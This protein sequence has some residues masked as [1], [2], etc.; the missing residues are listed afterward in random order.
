MSRPIC[1]ARVARALVA[2]ALLAATGGCVRDERAD[3]VA[4]PCPVWAADP[5]DLHSNEVATGLGCANLANFGSM[6][7]RPQDL[8]AGRP[9]G[10]ASGARQA[11][12][13]DIYEH[14]K[15]PA[16]H[17]GQPT[18]TFVMPSGQGGQSGQ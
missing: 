4:G 9:L 15:V 14:G 7:D 17:P 18:P 1:L 11:D 16:L 5:A 12:A 2:A 10:P 6:I 13:V 3:A 8:Q